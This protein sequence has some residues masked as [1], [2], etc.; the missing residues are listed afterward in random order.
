[1]ACIMKNKLKGG[2]V[3]YTIQVKVKDP[4]TEKTKTK[5][6]TWKK[7]KEMKDSDAK[8]H[9]DK[10]AIQFEEK[11][12][13]QIR[14]LV[15]D[16]EDIAFE[17]FAKKWLERTKDNKSILYYEKAKQHVNK[18][19][20]YFGK[21]KLKDIT[22]S[23]VQNFADSLSSYRIV[24]KVAICKKSMYLVLKSKRLVAKRIHEW[25][26]V[27]YG[28]YAQAQRRVPVK[29]ENAEKICK[30]L[31]INFDEYFE[32]KETSKPYARETKAKYIATLR[33]ILGF[34]KKQRLIDYNYATGEFIE[35]ITGSKREI[36]VLNDEEAKKLKEELDITENPR[37]KIAI[38]ILLLMGIRRGE[39]AGLDWDDID[40]ETKTMHIR[41]SRY[42]INRK[43]ITKTPKTETSIR[44]L[45]IPQI[46]I[47]KLLEY[48]KWYDERKEALGD[49][50][51]NAKALL[52]N[53]EGKI[54][55]PNLYRMWLRKILKRANL[56]QVT[57]HSLRH[58][59]IT[60]M[61]TSGIDLRTVSARA[62]H[63]RTSTTTDIY[64][65]FIRNSDERASRIID[66]IFAEK[67]EQSQ[68]N[69]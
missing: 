45:A 57:L 32:T 4:K 41:K 14:G 17:D 36:T 13:K 42:L 27:N 33:L 1:M 58:T 67:K 54:I 59:N 2:N 61:L 51:E 46:L 29:Y 8:R 31:N 55:Y 11:C 24:N 38:Y 7:P 28:T 18:F 26:D 9:V 69:S 6:M 40:F 53:D 22:P 12:R 44:S 43:L 66:D 62:G 37:W 10:L 20:E 39:L 49:L 5:V 48:K 47:D 16:D 68:D 25:C 64:S 30:A 52:V 21:L 34:A 56:K 50:W 60:L 3:S 15:G 35:P 63:A 65:H 23:I 19:V